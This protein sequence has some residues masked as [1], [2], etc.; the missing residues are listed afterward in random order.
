MIR[1]AL[2][3]LLALWASS[4]PAVVLVG[5]GSGPDVTA[6]LVSSASIGTNGTT[7]TLGMSETVTRTGGTFDVDCST[8]GNN[9][10]ATYSSGSGT[11]SLVYTLGATVQN[12]GVDTCD[13]DYDGAADGIEDGAGNDLAAITSQAITNSS[14]QGCTTPSGSLLTESFGDAGSLCWTGGPSTCDGT[15]TLTDATAAASIG[16]VPGT[17]LSNTACTNGLTFNTTNA[18]A[19]VDKTF[20]QQDANTSVDAYFTLYVTSHGI[21]SGSSCTIGRVTT[22]T[23]TDTAKAALRNNGGQ[24]EIS[25]VGAASGARITILTGDWYQVRLHTDA[26]EANSY[27]SLDGDVGCANGAADTAGCKKFTANGNARGRLYL[28]PFDARTV[29]LTIGNAYVE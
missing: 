18:A 25:G 13:L 7:L 16:A 23:G 8:T 14:S 1:Y 29:N 27:I 19:Q 2:A 11:A 28:G 6:P 4:A 21:G 20:T 24:L 22:S 26:T 15:W 5:F 17:P 9:I 3:V 12:S 10:T